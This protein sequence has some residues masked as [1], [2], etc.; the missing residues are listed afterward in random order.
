MITAGSQASGVVSGGQKTSGTDSAI[1]ASA[2]SYSGS[3][4]L[5]YTIQI[6]ST[7]PGTEVGQATFRW[8]TSETASG[9]WEATGVTTTSTF[10]TL[11]YGVTIAF[12]GG[13]G[14]DFSVGNTW[15]FTATAIYS[16]GKLIDL[17]RNTVFR[18]GVTFAYVI[19]LGSPQ[20][21]TALAVL[22]H[23]LTGS[24]TLT[25]QANSSDSWGAPPYSQSV[26]VQDPAILYLDQTYQY[27]RV[28]PVDGSL[29]YFQAGEM[30]LGTYT[31]LNK[32]NGWWGSTRTNGY[33]LQEN[34]SY[35]GLQR[36]KAYAKQRTLNLD[37]PVIGNTDI[38][39]LTTMQDAL[40]DLTTGDVKAVFVHQFYDEAD[41][42]FLMDWTN[43]NAVERQFRSYLQN[44]ISLQFVEQVKTRI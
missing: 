39:T 13:T 1:M 19:D 2:G 32:N 37:F 34:I 16:P 6:D 4:D 36:R 10:S 15:I 43:I 40:I 3:D 11:N 12:T 33:V 38:S 21:V 42:L 44:S 17:E 25:L 27:W 5:L 23:N 24:G 8:R 28:V 7:T 35:T 9:A 26:T 18:T 20:Q 22:D 31:Q 30:F 41:T 29:S 14:Q